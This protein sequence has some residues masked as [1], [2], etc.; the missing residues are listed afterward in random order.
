MR[1]KTQKQNRDGVEIF[2]DFWLP[3][4]FNPASQTCSSKKENM[5]NSITIFFPTLLCLRSYHQILP[6]SYQTT[7][8]N[9]K[10][11]VH[12]KKKLASVNPKQ[13]VFKFKWHY[14]TATWKTPWE[15]PRRPLGDPWENSLPHQPSHS[16]SLPLTAKPISQLE[17]KMGVAYHGFCHAPLWKWPDSQSA[18]ASQPA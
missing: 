16:P 2:F 17:Y 11:T 6:I 15:T 12:E 7:Q 5:E 14:D 13:P 1:K 10:I 4:F 18:S 3:R 9:Q 8:L